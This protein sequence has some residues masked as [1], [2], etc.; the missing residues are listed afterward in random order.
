MRVNKDNIVNGVCIFS[1]T[2]ASCL[3]LV[4]ILKS[5]Y[6]Q[7]IDISFIKDIF[8]IGVTLATAMVAIALFSDWKEQH[9]KSIEVQMAF[10][11]VDKFEIFD[12][13]I[14]FVYGPI[15]TAYDIEDQ[16]LLEIAV[17][18][19]IK[20]K[21]EKILE[22]RISFLKLCSEI[23]KF[24]SLTNDYEAARNHVHIS[25]NLIR[26]FSNKCLSIDENLPYGQYATNFMIVFTQLI[27]HINKIEDKYIKATL[28]NIK[29]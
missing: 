1:I 17:K 29:A 4:V 2:I 11:M 7:T 6:G 19:F 15:A 8:S 24:Y 27:P 26:D 18:D 13:Q 22:I 3:M 9:N 23:E 12:E 28:K 5:I 20:N 10:A 16:T 21:Q 25:K 14:T